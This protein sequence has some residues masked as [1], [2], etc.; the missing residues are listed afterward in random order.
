MAGYAGQ[1][2]AWGAGGRAARPGRQVRPTVSCEVVPAVARIAPAFA[3][4]QLT[5][6]PNRRWADLIGF[7]IVG[8]YEIHP[9]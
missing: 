8:T 2:A 6:Q 9:R 3:L 4:D 5:T 7:L 1:G